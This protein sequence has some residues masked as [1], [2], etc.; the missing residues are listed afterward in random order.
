MAKALYKRVVEET[1]TDGTITHVQTLLTAD[2]FGDVYDLGD[3]EDHENMEL[4]SIS[5][6]GD[7]A[8][9]LTTQE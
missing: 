3:Y 1:S 6:V 5:K 4:I 9:D 2:N 7:V 8:H